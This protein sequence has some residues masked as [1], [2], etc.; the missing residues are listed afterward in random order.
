M[1]ILTLNL[2]EFTGRYQTSSW[3]L[4]YVVLQPVLVAVDGLTIKIN[5]KRVASIS[6]H[7]RSHTGLI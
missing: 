4:V 1:Q 7:R 2:K 6:D 3:R 5:R